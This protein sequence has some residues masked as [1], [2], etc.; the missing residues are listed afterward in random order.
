[1]IARICLTLSAILIA[2]GVGTVVLQSQRAARRSPG[3]QQDGSTLLNSGWTLRPA[4]RQVQL[5]TFPMASVL[6]PDAK[7]VVVLNGGYNP[8]SLQVMDVK[9]EK[10]VSKAGVPDGWLGLVLTADGRRAYVG[11]GSKSAVFEFSLS[12]A[13]E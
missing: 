2:L 8:P 6:T 12:A 10:V 5:D 13:G 7:F 11:G 1:M 3:P 9:T 4:G